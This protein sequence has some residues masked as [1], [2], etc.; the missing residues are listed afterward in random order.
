MDAVDQAATLQQEDNDRALINHK[1]VVRKLQPMGFCQNPQCT[2]I[3]EETMRD[4]DK[5]LFCDGECAKEYESCL[6]R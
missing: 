2:L 4:M 3:F 6:K 1:K 5:K